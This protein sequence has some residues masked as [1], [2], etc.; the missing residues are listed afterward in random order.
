[1]SQM[2]YKYPGK[3]KIH[4]DFF[5]YIVVPAV[6]IAEKQAEGWYLTTQEA[7]EAAQ[8]PKV[9]KA[10]HEKPEANEED[11]TPPTREELE[12]KANELGIRFSK[13]TKDE[14][15]LEKINQAIE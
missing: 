9:K 12:A 2:L 15:L 4:G 1:M 3:E 7:K 11:N 14:T 10:K 13:V 5:N 6:E 8:N